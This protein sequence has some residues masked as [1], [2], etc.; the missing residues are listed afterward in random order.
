MRI[1]TNKNLL[2]A[3]RALADALSRQ[4]GKVW[5]VT[6]NPERKNIRLNF[7]CGKGGDDLINQGSFVRLLSHKGRFSDFITSQNI[8]TPSFSRD[9]P[10]ESDFPIIIRK[11]LS[12]FG[13]KGI[14]GVS[15]YE[16]YRKFIGEYWT[17]FYNIRSEFRVHVIGGRIIRVFKKVSRE[18]EERAFPIRN[19]ANG[20]HF[21]L[22]ENL[23]KMP[24]LIELIEEVS[25]VFGTR[26]YFA[27]DVGWVQNLH[28]WLLLECN[29]APGMNNSTTAELY[30]ENLIGMI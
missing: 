12:S 22:V 18:E 30:A 25:E 5:K 2:P 26:C 13:G 27:A 9:I 19:A 11:S 29:T 28:K 21:S 3:A 23:S 24:K 14:I 15:N 16:E 7:G 17:T 10:K 6:T 1:L 8:F 4:S 20:W